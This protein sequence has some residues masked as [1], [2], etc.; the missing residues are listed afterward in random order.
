MNKYMF[1][2]VFL[3]QLQKYPFLLFAVHIVPFGSHYND[4]SDDS[5]GILGLC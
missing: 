1:T 2:L 3:H 5:Q 4:I